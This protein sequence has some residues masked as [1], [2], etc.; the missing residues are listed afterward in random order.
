MHVLPLQLWG[1]PMKMS[2]PLAL[3]LHP[4]VSCLATGMVTKI[5]CKSADVLKLKG[6]GFLFVFPCPMSPSF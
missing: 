4:T 1:M 2:C 6:K 3:Y 5:S